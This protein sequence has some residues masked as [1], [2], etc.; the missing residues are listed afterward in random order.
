MRR[1]WGHLIRRWR[2]ASIPGVFVALGGY[3]AI[4]AFL[5]W[6]G[7]ADFLLDLPWVL[8]H[9][10]TGVMLLVLGI[11]WL[12]YLVK[13]PVSGGPVLYG[14]DSKP[15]PGSLHPVLP[16][17]LVATLL[18]TVDAA[19][20]LMVF[21]ARGDVEPGWRKDVTIEIPNDA[22]PNTI[23]VRIRIFGGRVLQPVR[24]RMIFDQNP[25]RRLSKIFRWSL[26]Q[27]RCLGFGRNTP[28][29]YIMNLVFSVQR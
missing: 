5:G 23:T 10:A 24:M 9:P 17:I 2:A 14:P 4:F 12:A 29:A 26:E 25:I 8:S 13:K 15:L 19:V 3:Q 7:K 16:V 1:N 11:A 21:P 20:T 28:V 6:I 22:D 27:P 18:A